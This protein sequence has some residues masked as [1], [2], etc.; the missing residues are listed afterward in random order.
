MI[1][2]GD[3][4]ITKEKKHILWPTKTKKGNEKGRQNL[5]PSGLIRT[6]DIV[7]GGGEGGGNLTECERSTGGEESQRVGGNAS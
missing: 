7:L 3:S 5:A 6:S 2:G 4:K 1:G